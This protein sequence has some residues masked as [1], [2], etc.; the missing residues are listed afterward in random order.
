MLACPVRYTL[1]VICLPC[2]YVP[3][4]LVARE[5]RDGKGG[6][7]RLRVR[8]VV[9]GVDTRP[10]TPLLGLLELLPYGRDIGLHIVVARRCTGF[11]RSSFEPIMSR[12]RELHPTVFVMNGS[13]EE[14]AIA[15]GRKARSLPAGRA[16][17]INSQDQH[18]VVQLAY[19]PVEENAE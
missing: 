5:L 2:V 16:D 6:P 19:L 7:V 10:D 18:Q 8:V 3:F 13:P 14:G 15:G 9:A 4:W 17:A 12:I 11:S 1:L